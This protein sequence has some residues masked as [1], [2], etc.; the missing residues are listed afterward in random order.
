MNVLILSN[1]GTINEALPFGS[2]SLYESTDHIVLL[3][4]LDFE[5]TVLGASS[6]WLIEFYS[7]WCGHCIKFAPTFKNLAKDVQGWEKIIKVGAVNCANDENM[8]L[9]REYEV[10]SY[11][12]LRFFPIHSEKSQ[13]G[14][15]DGNPR[16]IEEIQNKMIDFIA[17]QHHT[18]K[19]YPHWPSFDSLQNETLESFTAEH[20]YPDLLLLFLNPDKDNYWAKASILD[21]AS[22]VDY[23]RIQIVDSNNRDLVSQFNIKTFPALVY[24]IR[25]N[26][27]NKDTARDRK[28][29]ELYNI[30]PSR[31]KLAEMMSM[32]FRRT[33][34]KVVKLPSVIEGTNTSAILIENANSIKGIG[35]PIVV[36]KRSDQVF[37]V[38]LEKS[39]LYSFG[40]EV[41]VH[42]RISNEELEALKNYATV[43]DLYF[44]GRHQVKMILGCIKL[45]LDG[46]QQEIKGQMF[47][48]MWK[49]CINSI[50]PNWEKEVGDWVGCKGSQSHLRGY[51]CSV[52]TLFHTLTINVPS[53]GSPSAVLT[54]MQGYIQHFFGCSYCAKHFIEMAQEESN[55]LNGV[56]TPAEAVFWLWDAHNQVNRR[57][58]AD[59]SEDP[60]FPKIQ[61]PSVDNCILCMKDGE[62]DRDTVLDYLMTI[63]Q[64]DS[65]SMNGFQTSDA[66]DQLVSG[67]GKVSAIQINALSFTNYDLS[68]C[69]IVYFVSAMILLCVLYRMILKGRSLR[70]HTQSIY[71]KC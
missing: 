48:D 55:P 39:I 16:T 5:S 24:Y 68:L 65:I 9:C 56:Q 4:Y 25:K 18:K 47:D 8:G 26:T 60:Q 59:M 44:P 19:T 11:P 12:T 17:Q 63:Y 57:V 7:S 3:N 6:T 51:P 22:V 38:D 71:H 13:L 43:L 34:N 15:Q 20:N 14:I 1:I 53:D 45:K 28:T 2:N 52:W 30:E 33:S 54:A 61:F 21:S 42:A 37:M 41:S 62:F 66:Q 67:S 64:S 46:I 69:A 50:H 36:K 70:K 29:F 23:P 40:H 27:E 10:M 35:K 49:K 31:E 58:S 32:L